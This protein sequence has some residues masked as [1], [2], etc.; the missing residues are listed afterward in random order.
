M[1]LQA[2][3]SW[4]RLG[5]VLRAVPWPP[6]V[7]VVADTRL[8]RHRCTASPS[9]SQPVVSSISHGASAPYESSTISPIY[10]SYDSGS[11]IIQSTPIIEQPATVVDQP[12]TGTSIDGT[13]VP[14]TNVNQGE[15][16]LDS[17]QYESAKPAIDSD[18][19]M[20]TVAVPANA[21]VTVNDHPTTSDGAVRQFMSQGL[22]TGYVYTY[23]VKVV[24]END[25]EE[26]SEVKEVK[27]RAGESKELA[28]ESPNQDD[29][30]VDISAS[31]EIKE[32]AAVVT[33]D[34]DI[35]TV[36]RLHVPTD[37]NVTLAGNPTNGNGA[38]R[39]F[40]TKQLK[41]G[42]Q[43]KAYTVQVVATVNGQKITRER[44]IDVVAG[45]TN[46]LTFDFGTGD[47]VAIR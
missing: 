2:D 19:A 30:T 24:F 32:T 14:S 22:K 8:I 47:S 41:S 9:Y 4:L 29:N 43:W 31:A 21:M 27:L 42:E 26:K 20:L 46:E 18:A 13:V 45:S 17:T 33:P 12:V 15:T 35:V 10:E 37:A 6:L 7:E 23:V 11:S 39:T 40:R 44:T 1:D 5:A 36:V 3:R 25:G 38:I 16:S 34:D 28:F